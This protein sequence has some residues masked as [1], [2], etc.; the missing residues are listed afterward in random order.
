FCAGSIHQAGACTAL[1]PHYARFFAMVRR[2]AVPTFSATSPGG[3]EPR[4]AAHVDLP[5]Q[6]FS[7]KVKPGRWRLFKCGSPAPDP[8]RSRRDAFEP[9]AEMSSL[10]KKAV[11]PR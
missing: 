9:P 8:C 1:L 10:P 2:L 7:G 11:A 3:E 6:A 5:L 4:H